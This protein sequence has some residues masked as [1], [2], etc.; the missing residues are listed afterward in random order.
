MWQAISMNYRWINLG[1]MALALSIFL[2]S[3]SEDP[4]D[5]SGPYPVIK[6]TDGDTVQVLVNEKKVKVR[7]IG[8]DTPEI[9]STSKPV[10][11][12]GPESSAFA[13]DQLSGTSVFLEYDE[14]QGLVDRYGRTLAHVWT[15]EKKLYAAEA[16]LLGYGIE[17]TYGDEYKYREMFIDNQSEA[18]DQSLGLWGS[19]Q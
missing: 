7:I 5:L 9:V 2:T 13:E 16:I 19:C 10:Q 15:E 1:G 14:S 3:C 8:I 11:C 6:V 12:Y 4:S 18:R 17:K